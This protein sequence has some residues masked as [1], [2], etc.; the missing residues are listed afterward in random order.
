M[1]MISF[2]KSRAFYALQGEQ[3]FDGGYII[4]KGISA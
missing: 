4:S 2:R 3:D 1:L